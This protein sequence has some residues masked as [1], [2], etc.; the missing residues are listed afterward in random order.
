M[1]YFA[2]IGGVVLAGGIV[3]LLSVNIGPKQQDLKIPIE[4]PKVAT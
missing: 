1:R 2:I 3:I 4:V